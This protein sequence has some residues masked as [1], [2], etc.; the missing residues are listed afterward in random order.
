MKTSR[1][2]ELDITKSEYFL[3][4]Y[5]LRF[6]FSSKFYLEK[7]RKEVLEY[8]TIESARLINRYQIELQIYKTL[9]I[10]YYKKIE[11]RGFRIIDLKTKTEID[12]K[13]FTISD[14]N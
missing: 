9:S 3:E 2:I 1:G 10:A 8:I 11:K 7:F 6:Y 14:E 5:G 12:N 13:N 4:L